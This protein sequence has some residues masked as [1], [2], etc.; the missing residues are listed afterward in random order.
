MSIDLADIPVLH[1]PF[2]F[3]RHGE[4]TTNRDEILAGSLDVA[5]TE[6]GIEQA[7]AAA[8]HLRGRGIDALYVSALQRARR[9]ADEITHALALA[10]VV[11]PELNE[12]CWGVLEGKPRRLRVRGVTPPGA[13]TPE[14]FRD[15]VLRGFAR[16]APVG[17]PLVVSHSGV[18]HVLNDVLAIESKGERISNAL[19]V[20]IEPYDGGWR[21]IVL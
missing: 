3:V 10:P 5:L 6:L 7:R 11:V 19:P 13:E 8:Q 18:F 14:E 2:C 17:L 12:R 1:R 9:T 21:T 15:R 20:R 4:T 16:I